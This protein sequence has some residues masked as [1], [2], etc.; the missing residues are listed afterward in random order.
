MCYGIILPVR[1]ALSVTF[2]E[3]AKHGPIIRLFRHVKAAAVILYFGKYRSENLSL[4]RALN[5][6]RV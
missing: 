1:P 5:E 3:T 4:H 2:V 6:A